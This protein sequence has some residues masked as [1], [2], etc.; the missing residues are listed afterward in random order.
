MKILFLASNLGKGGVEKQLVMLSKELDKKG[1]ENYIL[2]RKNIIEYQV[3]Q[4]KIILFK[5]NKLVDNVK[6]VIDIV[7]EKKIDIIQAWEGYVSIIGFLTHLLVRKVKF[8]DN[9]IQYAKKYPWF[10][11]VKIRFSIIHLFSNRTVANSKAGLE[12]FNLKQN[13]KNRTIPNGFELTKATKQT[14]NLIKGNNL[15]VGM[16]ASFTK[17]KDYTTLINT[18]VH[19]LNDGYN[20]EVILIGDGPYLKKSKN[21][22]PHKYSGNFTFTGLLQ[23]PLNYIEAFDAGVLL[24]RKGHSEGMSNSIMEYMAMGKPVIATRTGGNPELI[25]DGKTGF[26]INFEDKKALY[27]KIIYLINNQ[28]IAK[29][30]G[31]AGYEKL[32]RY[33]QAEVYVN[34]WME[35]YNELLK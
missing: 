10:S 25:D 15:T 19:L 20:L 33:H 26:L 1:I 7:K 29:K 18:C 34:N 8:I 9:S 4:E 16:V 5:N 30:M 23:E 24:S 11:N 22:I 2:L 28:Q 32:T 31:K 27:N 13:R 6:G 21:L 3:N 14:N 35:L 12:A 17:A